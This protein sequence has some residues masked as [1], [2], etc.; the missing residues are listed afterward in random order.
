VKKADIVLE[1]SGSKENLK[2]EIENATI[3]RI[4]AKLGIIDDKDKLSQKTS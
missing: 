1:N 2:D 4:Y 3:D